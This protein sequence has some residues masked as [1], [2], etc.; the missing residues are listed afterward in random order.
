MN[1][2]HLM[3]GNIEQVE[4]YEHVSGDVIVVMRRMEMDVNQRLHIRHVEEQSHHES[5]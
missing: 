1:D 4:H 2:I 3:H 5:E